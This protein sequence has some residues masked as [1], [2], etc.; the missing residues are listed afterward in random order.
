[1]E[2]KEELINRFVAAMAGKW[3]GYVLRAVFV[4]NLVLLM[5]FIGRGYQ[6]D[7]HS[8]SAMKNLIAQEMVDTGRYFPADWNYVNGDLW[9]VFGQAFIAPLVPFAPNGFGLHAL[10]GLVSAA[11]ILWG[12]W[13]VSGLCTTNSRVRLVALCVFS[14]SI[15]WLVAENLYGQVSYGSVI[16]MACF[17][18]FSTWRVVQA[19]GRALVAWGVLLA[20]LST[21]AFWG[22]PQRAA[23]YYFLPI[24][25]AL[26]LLFVQAQLAARRVWPVSGRRTLVAGGLLLS[27]AVAGVLLHSATLMYVNNIDGAGSARWLPFNEIVR[28][29]GLALQGLFAILGGV[30]P[31]GESV[32]SKR[33][34]IEGTRFLAAGLTLALVPWALLHSIRSSHDGRR[35]VALVVTVCLALFLFLQ[36]CTTTPDMSDPVTSSRYMLPALLLGLLVVICAIG[37]V[38]SDARLRVLAFSVAL[39]F[40]GGVYLPGNPLS[41]PIYGFPHDTRKDLARYLESEGLRYGYATYWNAGAVTTIADQR[42]RVRQVLVR[43]GMPIPYRHLASNRW[44]RPEAWRGD[45]FLMLSDDEVKAIDWAQME[46]YA[47]APARR[48]RFGDKAVFVYRGNLAD[49]LPFWGNTVPGHVRLRPGSG[50]IG[51]FESSPDGDAL[52][53][54][55][56]ESGFLH[57]GPYLILGP[58]SYR[59][60]LLLDSPSGAPVSPGRVDVVAHQAKVMLAEAAIPPGGR[61]EVVLEFELA[62]TVTDLE[63]RVSSNGSSELSLRRLDLVRTGDAP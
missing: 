17:L 26:A 23:A 35:F 7:F 21:L 63:L 62:K 56:G 54:S 31:P 46:R 6:I 29:V 55:A 36:V 49:R 1:M 20:V 38:E 43:D 59:A 16:Y 11:L 10:S 48:L 40:V 41:R 25:A 18:I 53:A 42:V 44:F 14:G 28:N 34:L 60:T 58:G 30:L 5:L 45:T 33:G 2:L 24:G 50:Q 27:G 4:L 15:S 13:L 32:M 39:A 52:I 8:D 47:G 61:R 22:N 57:F 51:R 37:D 19:N 3:G 12:I 9:V